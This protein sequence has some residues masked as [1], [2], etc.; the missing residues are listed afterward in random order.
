MTEG[1][2]WKKIA[3]FAVPMLV[4]NLFQQLYSTADA[5]MLGH[6]VGDGALAAVGA[7]MPIFFLILVLLIGLAMGVGIMV[8][9]YLGAKKREE[10]SYTI[11][12]GITLITI[13]SVAI[14]AIGPFLT[15][16]ILN[17]LSTPAEIMDDSVVYMNILLIGVLPIAYFNI[18]SGVLRSLGDSFSPLIYLIVTCVLNVALNFLL[19]PEFG[20]H[21]AALGTVVSQAVSS[22]LCFRRIFKMR[23]VF[24]MGKSY[25]V[26]K[27][28]YVMQI[29][30]LGVPSGASQVIIALSFMIVQPLVNSF[31]AM[32]I[33]TNVIIM[34]IDSI[35]MMP[36]FS[37]GNALTVFAGQNVGA[38]K[39]DRVN[40]GTKQGAILA[41]G[42]TLV[43]VTIIVIFGR[44]IAGAFTQTAEVIDMAAGWLRLLGIGFIPLSLCMVLWGTIRGAG[45][46]ISPMW[47]SIV[48]S[49]I[50]R[51]PVAY[52]LVHLIG[53][54][55]ALIY[56]IIIA[57][58]SNTLISIFVFKLGKWRTKG[59]VKR[60]E[61]GE[62][63]EE[64]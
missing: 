13:M 46:A 6:F 45:D 36:I 54:P 29:L 53:E 63:R 40:Q 8:S 25:L 16:P 7:T 12:T 49:I 27:R 37:F 3:L 56:S 33:A 55:I 5:I 44:F 31:G 47:G 20:V 26:P 43:M 2:P 64:S 28:E 42:T 39:M 11:G 41:V 52:L 35:V 48:N 24:D 58:I 15:R 51:I 23:D 14:M 18:L 60:V 17:L 30:K 22:V 19:I 50:V 38:G 9:Q 32:I 10:L 62:L 59:I 1:K 21:G 61:R 34:R 4:G 57:W